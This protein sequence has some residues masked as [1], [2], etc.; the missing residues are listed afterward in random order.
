MLF[1][2]ESFVWNC[3]CDRDQS[4]LLFVYYS[5]YVI[6]SLHLKPWLI[7]SFTLWRNEAG[8]MISGLSLL[9]QPMLQA[10]IFV[11][12]A[13]HAPLKA[14][15]IMLSFNIAGAVEWL[16]KRTTGCTEK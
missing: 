12:F 16:Y 7:L 10:M 6:A 3:F 11:T 8:F 15:D 2:W 1:I 13:A 14:T 5:L 9:S 4:A